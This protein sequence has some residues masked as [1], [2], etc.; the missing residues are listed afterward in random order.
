MTATLPTGTVTF[1]FVDIEGSTKLFD[2]VG[3]SEYAHPLGINHE[4]MRD[5]VGADKEPVLTTEGDVIFIAFGDERH[6]VRAAIAAQDQKRIRVIIMAS[7][8]LRRGR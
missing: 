3:S 2:R 8:S 7:C 4:A 6:A 5:A 1:L